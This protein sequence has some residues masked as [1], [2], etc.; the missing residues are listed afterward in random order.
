M[1]TL[2]SPGVALI[3]DP[4]R[5]AMQSVL[6]KS[7]IHISWTARWR[8]RCRFSM[9]IL[10]PKSSCRVGFV[11]CCGGGRKALTSVG[12]SPRN[13]QPNSRWV[14]NTPCTGHKST[15]MQCRWP[16][17]N[18]Q[19]APGVEL[20]L[21]MS[22]G[23]CSCRHSYLTTTTYPACRV[24]DSLVACEKTRKVTLPKLFAPICH[25]FYFFSPGVLRGGG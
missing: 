22:Q 17:N 16:M 3:R 20:L 18:R 9:C 7:S 25:V 2:V 1:D 6:L 24:V 14:K 8:V 4:K 19:R 15:E 11:R 13:R 23:W 21:C 5:E 12:C 10:A